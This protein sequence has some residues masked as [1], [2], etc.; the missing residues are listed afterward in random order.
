[1]TFLGYGSQPQ[2]VTHL[3]AV[4]RWT[5]DATL[6]VTSDELAAQAKALGVNRVEI[7]R[8]RYRDPADR[9][10]LA[11]YRDRADC[12]QE[13][14]LAL[15]EH[16]A[17]QVYRDANNSNGYAGGEGWARLGLVLAPG[18]HAANHWRRAYPGVP[19][20]HVG[21]LTVPDVP[22]VRPPKWTGDGTGWDRTPVV[23]F[24][25]HWPCNQAPE[26][27][28]GLDDWW[29]PVEALVGRLRRQP[30]RFHLDVLGHQHPRWLR[31]KRGALP[32]GWERIGVPVV[33]E[34]ERVFTEADLLVADNTSMLYEF[35]ATGKPVLVLNASRYRR[36]VEHGL[37]FWSHVPGHML[38]PGDDLEVGIRVALADEKDLRKT[39]AAAMAEAYGERHPSN[40]GGRRGAE[41]VLAWASR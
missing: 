21:P 29:G 28:H 12:R 26:S 8:P 41:W 4:M 6:L 36:T 13:Q 15:I 38:D 25:F 1:M 16:G 30:E 23:A 27:W 2:Y 14:P 32:R 18:P 9:V 20:R 24:T 11:G 37:R 35:A 7:G 3:A 17:G 19:I 10:L 33:R 22:K 39:R 34:P 31:M 5:P 40:D